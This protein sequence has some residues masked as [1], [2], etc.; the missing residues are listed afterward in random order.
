MAPQRAYCRTDGGA[1]AFRTVNE[2]AASRKPAGGPA[3]A[4]GAALQAFHVQAAGVFVEVDGGGV[5]HGAEALEE[6]QEE[7]NQGV[8]RRAEGY[9]AR[10]ADRLKGAVLE[11]ASEVELVAG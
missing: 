3:A 5:S 7:E 9:F 4:R 2:S 1:T 6:A 11:G 8:L 10:I